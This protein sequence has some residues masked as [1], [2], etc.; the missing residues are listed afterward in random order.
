[1]E[2][3]TTCRNPFSLLC[4]ICVAVNTHTD[5]EHLTNAYKFKVQS[6]NQLMNI[7]YVNLLPK[8]IRGIKR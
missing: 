4:G 1:M 5:C 3:R 7:K 2:V 8:I 6:K